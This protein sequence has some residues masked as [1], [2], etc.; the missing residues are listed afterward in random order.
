MIK[1]RSLLLVNVC[2]FMTLTQIELGHLGEEESVEASSQGFRHY[3][4]L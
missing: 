1:N 2:Q 4:G 3:S